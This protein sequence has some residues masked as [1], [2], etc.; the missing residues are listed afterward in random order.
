[1]I[2]AKNISTIGK[3]EDTNLNYIRNLSCEKIFYT[4]KSKYYPKD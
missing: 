2:H 1:M 4:V 3:E